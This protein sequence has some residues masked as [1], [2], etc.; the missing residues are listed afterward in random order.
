M[1]IVEAACTQGL[2]AGI[3]RLA[4]LEHRPVAGR[5]L[6]LFH[7]FAV[8]FLVAARTEWLFAGVVRLA[9]LEHRPGLTGTEFRD[10]LFA[11][12][13]QEAASTERL[14]AWIRL[15][16]HAFLPVIAFTLEFLHECTSTIEGTTCA[17]R[18]RTGII[19]HAVF[20]HY[21][22]VS[23]TVDLQDPLTVTILIAARTP[24]L[25]TRIGIAAEKHRPPTRA[26][27]LQNVLTVTVQV[28]A[29]TKRLLARVRVAR[30]VPEPIIGVTLILG[31]EQALAVFV[32]A[33][34]LGY[35][36]RIGV[37]VGLRPKPVA[38]NVTFV[39][40]NECAGPSLIAARTWWDGASVLTHCVPP[41]TSEPG[42][43][44]GNGR[45]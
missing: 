1:T 39:F 16:R 12:A 20:E 2:R 19:R 7:V 4:C 21:P 27:G 37:A 38:L 13:I 40:G 36:A 45:V 41:D 10:R 34:S 22:V 29:C 28:A 17:L 3:V 14:R 31:N 32:A 23:W 6:G 44:I 5:A 43:V 25:H 26:I 18:L 30:H 8:A 15:A 9:R 33:R 11:V 24:R 35:V 42:N